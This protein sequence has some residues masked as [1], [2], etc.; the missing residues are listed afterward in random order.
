MIPY[1]ISIMGSCFTDGANAGLHALGAAKRSLRSM[2][3][4]SLI[5]LG[6]GIIGAYVDGAMGV[7]WGAA[8]ATW[9]GAALWWRQLY[10]G[11]HEAGHWSP[12][13]A[14]RGLSAWDRPQVTVAAR[15]G[16]PDEYSIS[17]PGVERS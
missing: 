5:Y 9:L 7:V 15:D 10:N 1:A 3:C 2:I 4:S 8:F 12:R 17:P 14:D 11:M 6:F 16:W 13:G